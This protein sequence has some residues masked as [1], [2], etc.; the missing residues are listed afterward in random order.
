MKKIVEFFHKWAAEILG[1]LF[2]AI[3][4]LAMFGITL[5]LFIWV[6]RLLGVM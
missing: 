5:K 3:M 1:I 2:S 4:I 6:L